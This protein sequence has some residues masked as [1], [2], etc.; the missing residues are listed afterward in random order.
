MLGVLPAEGSNICQS[1]QVL[2]PE[3]VGIKTKWTRYALDGA[4]KSETVHGEF[5][6]SNWSTNIPIVVL[7]LRIPFAWDMQISIHLYSICI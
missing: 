4:M 7:H 3:S 1:V 5:Q 2:V 6:N